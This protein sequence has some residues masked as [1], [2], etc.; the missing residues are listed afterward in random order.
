MDHADAIM[1]K[2]G[3]GEIFLDYADGYNLM[4]RI[5]IKERTRVRIIIKG[6]DNR[7]R[8][9]SDLGRGPGGNGW[10]QSLKAKKRQRN[11]FFPLE[12]SRRNQLCQHLD[13]HY[14]THF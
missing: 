8:K 7:S 5:T 2:L 4:R 3:E 9:G 1:L 11:R 12:A 6:C 14:K 10:G 13:F